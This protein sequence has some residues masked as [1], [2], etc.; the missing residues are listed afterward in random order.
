MINKLF[1]TLLVLATSCTNDEVAQQDTQNV[2]TK[3]PVVNNGSA[4]IINEPVRPANRTTFDLTIGTP[5]GS[6][7]R[8]ICGGEIT[9]IVYTDQSLSFESG[10]TRC[11]LLAKGK[12]IAVDI[13]KLLGS[14]SFPEG[15]RESVDGLYT[16]IIQRTFD[17]SKLGPKVDQSPGNALRFYPSAFGDIPSI[18]NDPADLFRRFNLTTQDNTKPY[19]LAGGWLTQNI[20]AVTNAKRQYRGSIRAKIRQI[21]LSQRV[22]NINLTNIIEMEREVAGFEEMP[23]YMLQSPPQL[24]IQRKVERTNSYPFAK[25]FMRWEIK[26]SALVN[27]GAFGA[28]LIKLFL[29]DKVI[30]EWKATKILEL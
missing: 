21:G 19:R 8:E 24:F 22:G 25:V 13:G 30:F 23:T 4:G 7:I 5:R 11:H 17:M 9:L 20:T 27:S 2:E 18:V 3:T 6:G 26:P 15:S 10:D 28:T 29:G 1:V 14:T 16:G 12:G